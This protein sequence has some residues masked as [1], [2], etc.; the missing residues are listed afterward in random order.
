MTQEIH[1]AA[2]AFFPKIT[3]RRYQRLAAYFNDLSRLW[4]AEFG[5]LVKAGWEEEISHEFLVWREDKPIEYYLEILKGEQISFVSLPDPAY[6]RLLK[7]INDPPLAIFYRGR[8]PDEN[9]PA[10]AVVGT[11]RM[12]P[13]GAQVCAELVEDLARRGLLIVSGLALGLDGAAHRAALKAGGQT[14]AVLGSSV[15]RNHIYPPAHQ[16]LAEEIINRGGAVLAE[17]PPGFAP[18]NYS[19]P[20]RNRII[21]GLTLGTLV[22]EAPERSGALITAAHA[23]D[24]NREVFAVPQ[25]IYSPTGEGTNN[26]IKLGARPVT[27]AKD[28][29]ETLNLKGLSELVASSPIITLTETEKQ[30]MDCL[31]REPENIDLIIKKTGLASSAVNSA[32]ATL[33]LKD[34]TKNYGGMRYGKTPAAERIKIAVSQSA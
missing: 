29:I 7:E 2:L 25:P 16:R 33:E 5:D 30:V 23:L 13:Y 22:I 9:Q 12:T 32:L 21:A 18:T 34:L 26:L 19:F 10:L 8:L 17:Y 4:Q 28:I 3:Y 27:N 20:A 24:Y 1:H 14:I 31:G 6:P 15:D 11:R